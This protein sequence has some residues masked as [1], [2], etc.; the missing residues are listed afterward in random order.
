[1]TTGL[2]TL[3]FVLSAAA[4][5]ETR[6]L[7]L[8]EYRDKVRGAW[9]GQIA[10]AIYGWPFEGKARSSAD[11]DH[12]LKSYTFAPVDDD[13]F[14][15]MVALYGFERFGTGMTVEQLGAMWKEYRAGSWGS[16]EQARLALEKGVQAP[17]TGHPRYNRWYHTIGPQ[18]SSD[19]YGMLAP[20]MVNLAGETARRYGHVN[21]YAEGADG[22]VFVAACVSEAF[23][24]ANTV[25]I[26]RQAARLIHPDSPYRKA[27]DQVLA[28]YDSGLD[29][30]AAARRSEERWRPEYPQMNNAVANGALIAVG[31]LYGEG[32]YLKSLN[33]V[34]QAGDNTDADCNAANIGAVLGARNGFAAIPRQLVEPLHDRI[35]GDRMGPVV[36]GRVIDE[37]IAGLAGRIAALGERILLEHGAR[38]DAESLVIP[39]EA[40]RTQALEAFDVNEYAGLWRAGWKMEGASTN[41]YLDG[42]TLV[43]S[44]R[45]GRPCLLF[46]AV[47]LGPAPQF[48]AALGTEAGH[49]WRL[50]VFVNDELVLNRVIDRDAEVTAD[51][52]KY[53]RQAVT[54]RLYQ[55]VEGRAP[56]AARW[57]KADIAGGE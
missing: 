30:R 26:V 20:G 19:L 6:R 27:I 7:P 47:V 1:M 33:I 45:D 38:R 55:W 53:A 52:K 25:K 9:T 43:T 10:G 15:E 44:P 17:L 35:Y 49:P 18:F 51:L 22:A 16:S 31:L 54:L 32:Q 24:E 42:E 37:S 50:Q 36:F 39:R 2:F 57:R 56:A 4:A 29:W 46:R 28:G 23:F 48:T 13:Y 14:Y 8:A 12:Y 34:T 11:L 41:S 40:A 3:L 21:G 5:A